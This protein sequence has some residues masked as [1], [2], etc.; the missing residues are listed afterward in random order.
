[1][2]TA[3][4]TRRRYAGNA[5]S[6]A[7]LKG[8]LL[9]GLL[10]LVTGSQAFAV[11]VTV[12]VNWPNWSSDNQVVIRNPSGTILQTI[13]DP[14]NCANGAANSSYSNTFNYNFPEGFD[15]TIEM[16]DSFGDG[17][18]G[19]GAYVRVYSDGDLVFQDAGPAT[20]SQTETFDVS[21]Q[22]ASGS[23]T[24]TAFTGAWSGN[25]ASTTDGIGVTVSTTANTGGNWLASGTDTL[26]TINTFS[27]SSVQGH[28]SLVSTYYW[29]T[30]G[31]GSETD[32]HDDGATGTYS[33]T[34][35]RPVYNPVFHFDRIGG[36]AGD[37]TNL[38]NSIRM[39]LT[40]GGTLVRLGGPSHFEVF[41]TFFQRTIHESLSPGA[42]AESSLTS[43][44][45]TAAGSFYVAGTHTTVTF[46]T[47]GRGVEGGG[48]DAFEMV[49]CAQTMD[50]SDVPANG[51]TAPDGSGTISYGEATH[52][53]V[54]GIRLGASI[55]DEASAVA[56]ADD[57]GSGDGSDDGVVVPDLPAGATTDVTISAASLTGSGTG[58]LHAWIDFDGDGSFETAEYASVAFSNGASADLTFSGYGT[59]M[60]AGTTY[61]RFRLT[62]D[63]SVTSAT[64]SSAA[65]DGEVEDYEITVNPATTTLDATKTVDVWD[66]GS[67]GLYSV[68]GNDVVYSFTISNTGNAATDADSL[69]LID[70]M[71]PEIEFYNGDI[72]DG[73][74]ETDPVSFN[75]S[76]GTGLSLTYATD[77]GF[78][79]AGTKPANFSGCTYTPAAGY[80]PNVTYICFNPKGAL[81]FGDPD[82]TFT[83]QFRGRLK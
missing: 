3:V 32:A 71:P 23:L 35:D 61:A 24:C 20:S 6:Y 63:A 15:Y 42:V 12:E 16:T 73:G 37:P 5:R 83:L 56:G 36:S 80:D 67:I 70:S 17:W 21:A 81:D 57:T 64:P 28:P 51:G 14:S 72:D 39:S 2:V 55:T 29:D 53:N 18:N 44:T 62:S 45:G 58:T 30:T 74:P 4:E 26:N 27:E 65:L 25:T 11:P 52:N 48:G 49:A 78:S 68:P 79:N 33:I 40:S 13:C 31:E 54:S 9:A 46:A 10:W 43:T 69:L 22:A 19:T 1:M 7:A 75:Q 50:Y 66:P 76:V 47:E 41:D 60:A 77:V 59:T 34:F 8:L 38:S 82:P